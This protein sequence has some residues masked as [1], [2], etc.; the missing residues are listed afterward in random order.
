MQRATGAIDGPHRL[1]EAIA[2]VAN[3]GL[4]VATIC[5]ELRIE[6]K[7]FFSMVIPFS[8]ATAIHV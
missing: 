3:I 6:L 4:N 1:H 5:L 7:V 2:A 8:F